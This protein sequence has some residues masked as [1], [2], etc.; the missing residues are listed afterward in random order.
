MRAPSRSALG[1]AVVLAVLL[2]GCGLGG[3][4]AAPAPT[5][6]GTEASGTQVQ[7]DGEVL[8][9]S[10][11]SQSPAD[12]GSEVSVSDDLPQTVLRDGSAVGETS[13]EVRVAELLGGLDTRAA[14]GET[15]VVLAEAILF[16]FDQAELR[17][18]SQASLQQVAELLTLS[19]DPGIAVV[20]HTDSEGSPEYNVELSQRRAD[21]VSQALVALGTDPARLQAEGRGETEPVAPNTTADG[22]DDPEG[23]AANRRVEIVVDDLPGQD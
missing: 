14:G 11:V 21:A 7:V 4:D 22:A 3:D 23:R 18:G 15:V 20:G 10:E 2:G 6:A 16:D 5:A 17:E 9:R 19:A 12:P 1:Q 13:V 8:A